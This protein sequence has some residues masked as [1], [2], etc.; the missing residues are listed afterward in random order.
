[1]NGV[2]RPDSLQRVGLA[3]SVLCAVH[4]AATPVVVLVAPQLGRV[5][6]SVEWAETGLLALAVTLSLWLLYRGAWRRRQWT[7]VALF[8]AAVVLLVSGLVAGG[9]AIP[10]AAGSLLLGG[11]QLSN[12]RHRHASASCDC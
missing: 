5:F 4:C 3:A 6:S 8:G 7:P 2:A 9:G 11:A 1:M 12:L 10:T